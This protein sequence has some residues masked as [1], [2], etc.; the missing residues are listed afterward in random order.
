MRFGIV[1]TG[2]IA[3]FHA[4]AIAELPGCSLVAC[5]DAAAERAGAFAAKHG[6]R[7]YADLD[8]FLAHDGLDIVTVCTP[9]GTHMETAVA[10]ARAGKHLIVEKPIEVTLERVD[11]I[12][13][14][15]RENGTSLSGVFMSRYGEAARILKKAVDEGRFGRLTLG[16]AYVKWWRGQDYYVPGGWKGTRRYDGGGA[17]MNQ[18]IHAVDLLQWCMG[19][20]ESVLAYGR[21]WRTGAWKWRTPRWR[22]SAS[23]TAPSAS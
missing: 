23:G 12:V 5:M 4:A 22:R 20:V 21:P 11:A 7:P 15:C 9:S 3:E 16:G 18:G 14:A 2:M 19:P 1:G 17:L 13:D 6:C 10:S 8:G